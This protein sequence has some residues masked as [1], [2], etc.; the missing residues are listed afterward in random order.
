MRRREFLVTTLVASVRPMT[1]LAQAPAQV[2]RVGVLSPTQAA[3]E[4]IRQ[5][6]LP[7]LA[8]FGFTEGRNL[9]VRALSADGVWERLPALGREIV[10]TGPDVIIAVAPASIRAARGYQHDSHRDVLRR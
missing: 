2:R 8:K 6:T 10:E 5:A 4:A 3:V 1:S 7:E 9:E